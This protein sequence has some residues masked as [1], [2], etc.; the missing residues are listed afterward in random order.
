[1]ID[2]A[3]RRYRA[4]EPRIKRRRLYALLMRRGFDGDTIERALSAPRAASNDEA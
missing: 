3:E 2:Q 1:M 4:L